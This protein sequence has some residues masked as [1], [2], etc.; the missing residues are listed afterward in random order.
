MQLRYLDVYGR[1]FDT[2]ILQHKVGWKYDSRTQKY[3]VRTL[4]L[5]ASVSRPHVILWITFMLI[6]SVLLGL[7]PLTWISVIWD[8]IID[9]EFDLEHIEQPESRV[10]KLFY[11]ASAVI[12]TNMAIRNI[13]FVVIGVMTSLSAVLDLIIWTPCMLENPRVREKHE[14]R[15]ESH[16]HS[17]TTPTDVLLP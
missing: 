14:F 12:N 5:N 3:V 6:Y 7:L 1:N 8:Q 15:I 16:P 4:K 2:D 17:R 9:P 13:C 11:K 10:I